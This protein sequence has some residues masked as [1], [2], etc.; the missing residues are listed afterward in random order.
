[1]EAGIGIG[2]RVAGE[3]GVAGAV[4]VVAERSEIRGGSAG[5]EGSDAGVGSGP[6]L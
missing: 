2:R 4:A 3:A 5:R 6:K 1:M